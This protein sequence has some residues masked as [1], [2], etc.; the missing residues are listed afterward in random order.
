[1]QTPPNLPRLRPT[2]RPELTDDEHCT[3]AARELEAA[4]D[5]LIRAMRHLDG[6]ETRQMHFEAFQA[7]AAVDQVRSMLSQREANLDA[8]GRVH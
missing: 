7:T 4:H 3:E 2:Y 1:M 5:A 8:R 6:T